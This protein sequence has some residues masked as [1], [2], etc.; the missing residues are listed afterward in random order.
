[1]K[2]WKFE[3]KV[4]SREWQRSGSRSVNQFDSRV[5][6]DNKGKFTGSEPLDDS[7]RSIAKFLRYGRDV[8]GNTCATG[9]QSVK[10]NKILL[11]EGGTI[12][13]T[14]GQMVKRKQGG[15]PQPEHG[16]SS[17]ISLWL[18]ILLGGPQMLVLVLCTFTNIILFC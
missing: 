18:D 5:K 6:R 8:E 12:C 11:D 15:G 10:R 13:P 14:V 7:T 9:A 4:L 1:M 17:Q 2:W 16:S 3:R